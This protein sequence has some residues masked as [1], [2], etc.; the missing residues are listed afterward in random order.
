[1]LPMQASPLEQADLLRLE[2]FL[3]SDACGGDA[4]GLSRAHGFLTAAV[5]GPEG[6]A[7]DEWIRLVFDEPVFASGE[8]AEEML[9]LAMRLYRDIEAGLRVS[10]GFHP[11]LE[12][13]RDGEAGPQVDAHAWCEGFLSGMHLFREHWTRAAQALLQEPLDVISRLARMRPGRDGRY[14]Q[15]CEALPLAAEVVYL[16]WREQKASPA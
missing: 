9:G 14:T 8:Q 12:Y 4:M 7:P 2:H 1:M 13:L 3:R 6:L 11:V 10:G 16:F 15:L 5:S